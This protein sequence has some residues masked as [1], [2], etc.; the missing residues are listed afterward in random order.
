MKPR[1]TRER[2]RTASSPLEPRRRRA[3]VSGTSAG[4][5]RISRR[6]CD[7]AGLGDAHARA[8]GAGKERA[9]RI[10]RPG[11][12]RR[13]RGG[14]QLGRKGSCQI[15]S[16]I[17]AAGTAPAA[18]RTVSLRRSG[19][20]RLQGAP[21]SN[22][23]PNGIAS[24]AILRQM[25]WRVGAQAAP[26]CAGLGAPLR[27]IGAPWSLGQSSQSGRV[28]DRLVLPLARRCGPMIGH[29]EHKCARGSR[30]PAYTR[31]DDRTERSLP[32]VP[33]LKRRGGVSGSVCRAGTRPTQP[34]AGSDGRP[35]QSPCCA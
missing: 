35:R 25:K 14:A 11:C 28:Q 15:I 13:P 30:S 27:A 5:S 23:Q 34:S 10:G 31:A 26:A 3:M 2:P 6:H 17:G 29:P 21:W 24:S 33:G 18:W 7:T 1:A 22:I 4:L 19:P 20:D 12:A 9:G 8:C 32:P 16:A